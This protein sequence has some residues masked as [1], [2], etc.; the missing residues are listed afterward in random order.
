VMT[1]AQRPQPGR[2][3]VSLLATPATA[4]TMA[5]GRVRAAILASEWEAWPAA[6]LEPLGDLDL[7]VV[8]DTFQAGLL[9]NTGIAVPVAIVPFGVDRE[10]CHP[11]VR[12]PRHPT[13]RMLFLCIVEKLGRDQADAVVR[14]FDAAFSAEDEVELLVYIEPG[15]DE[16]ALQDMLTPIATRTRA[17]VRVIAGRGFPPAERGQLYAAADVYVSARRS[18]GWDPCIGEAL[19]SGCATAGNAWGSAADVLERWGHPVKAGAR[20]EDAA[21]PGG[22]W[23]D[24][25]VDAL[26]TCL[27]DLHARRAE[28]TAMARDRAPSFAALH[29]FDASADALDALFTQHAG[30]AAMAAPRPHRPCDVSTPPSQQIVVLGMHRAGTSS[31]GGL[32]ALFG[33]WPGPEPLLLRGDDNPKG[34]FEH[35]EIHMACL[36][37]LAAAGG[38]WKTPPDQSPTAAVDAFRREVAAVLETLEPQRPWFIK[39]PRL[40]LLARLLLPLL[41][42][43]VFVHVTRDPRA[44]ADSLARRDGMSSDDALVLWERY[45][46][47]AFAASAGWPRIVVDYDALLSEPTQTARAMFDDLAGVGAGGLQMPISASILE[48]IDIP[49]RAPLVPPLRLTRSQQQ[50][51]DAINDRSILGD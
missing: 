17:I 2:A 22:Y 37:R 32:L 10:Y 8:P 41:T 13:H 21:N 43:P 14:A 7:I 20:R 1:A 51:L 33:A 30:L 16:I 34:H 49:A 29:S 28:V 40:C 11:S 27:R 4:G 25:D 38:D 35:G 48:W 9:R 19:A 31:V 24:I 42:H 3:D 45:T 23:H 50:L 39:E 47:D 15:V 36:R 5:P 44:V 26:A 18:A 12:A 46:R 6:A